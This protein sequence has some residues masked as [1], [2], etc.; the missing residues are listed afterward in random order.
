MD[1]IA[2]AELIKQTGEFAKQFGVSA[3]GLLILIGMIWRAWAWFKP[4]GDQIIKAHVSLVMNTLD[5]ETPKQSAALQALSES[6]SQMAR[7]KMGE[8]K[9]LHHLSKAVEEVPECDDRRERV[10][11]HTENMR[12]ELS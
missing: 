3:V 12:K 5:T 8:T 4:H 7:L 9:A 6:V 10:K 1:P 2:I 11:M